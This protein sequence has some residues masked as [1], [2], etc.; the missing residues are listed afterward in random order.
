MKS[1]N[2]NDLENELMHKRVDFKSSKDQFKS[3]G[4]L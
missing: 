3:T 1:K 2:Q 4:N